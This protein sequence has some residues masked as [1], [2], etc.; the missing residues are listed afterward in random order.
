MCWYGKILL[1]LWEPKLSFLCKYFV[2][3]TNYYIIL[4]LLYSFSRLKTCGTIWWMERHE[5]PHTGKYFS[6]VGPTCIFTHAAL[7]SSWNI[8]TLRRHLVIL[9]HDS[10]SAFTH[11]SPEWT[12]AW[13]R[14]WF[15]PFADSR[16]SSLYLNYIIY[17][18]LYRLI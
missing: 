1:Y 11:C 15:L 14:K 13:R 9:G 5:R 8:W 7:R 4:L 2:R 17:R 3:N 18:Y 10:Q 6:R 16:S 12:A